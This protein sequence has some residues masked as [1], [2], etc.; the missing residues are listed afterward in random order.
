VYYISPDGD[1]SGD[2]SANSP[3]RTLGQALAQ[4]LQ[5]GDAVYFRGG[6]YNPCDHD[7][8]TATIAELKGTADA[9]ITFSSA[10][11]ELATFDFYYGNEARACWPFYM[12]G[13]TQHIVFNGFR[14]QNTNPYWDVARAAVDNPTFSSQACDFTNPFWFGHPMGTESN[15]SNKPTHITIQNSQFNRTGTGSGY[16]NYWTFQG[17]TVTDTGGQPIYLVGHDNRVINNT[18]EQI[19]GIAIRIGNVYSADEDPANVHNND[20]NT[21][22]EGNT[23]HLTGIPTGW[24]DLGASCCPIDQGGTCGFSPKFDQSHGI[25]LFVKPE[26]TNMHVVNNVITGASNDPIVDF[27]AGPGS[28]IENNTIH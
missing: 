18:F 13:D 7:Y 22:I 3:W 10:P 19:R 11:G 4:G 2:G 16:L 24:S 9:P 25:V 1:D 6:M 20:R 27:S 15:G 17:N 21:V 23:I 14:F 12:K 28:V 26:S 5:P 8:T